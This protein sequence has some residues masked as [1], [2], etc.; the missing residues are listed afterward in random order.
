[1]KWQPRIRFKNRR[2]V[3]DAGILIL[4]M[5]VAIIAIIAATLAWSDILEVSYVKLMTELPKFSYDSQM[6][7]E[8]GNQNF[9][10][11][12]ILRNV[13]LVILV[14]VLFFA[15]MSFVFEH[16]NLIPP[17]TGYQI[18]SKSMI[19]IFFFFFFPPLWDLISTAVE[20]TSLW[21]LNP[22]D[23]TQPAKNVEFLL[24]KLGLID[25]PKF[26]LDA[27]VAGISDPFTSLKNMFLS[28]FLSIFKAVAFLIFM[29]M[30]FLFGTIRVVLTSIICVAI[31]VILMLSLIPFFKRV[32][33]RFIDA[34][35]GLIITPIFSSLVIV[36]GVA[37]LK[38]L[39]SSSPDPMVEW[40][41]AL[42]VM[43][44]ATF[45]PAMIVPMLNSVIGSVSSV[46]GRSV[47][48][49][50]QLTS[51]AGMGLGRTITDFSLLRGGIDQ[52]MSGIT[53]PLGLV[54]LAFSG[55][56]IPTIV[57]NGVSNIA[58]QGQIMQGRQGSLKMKEIIHGRQMF[59]EYNLEDNKSKKTGLDDS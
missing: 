48:T 44:L 49:G 50:M 30:A 4:G 28:I 33:N 39:E 8:S 2:G 25:S 9:E 18:L 53:E 27:I 47:S 56:P 37:H 1:M 12:Q 31:P 19:Y 5:I 29:F 13:A 20:Q 58:P 16:I 45:M 23:P 22:S 40:F 14:L 36:A 32:T 34:L 51:I 7:H 41:S 59:P 3:L 6:G 42:A 54:K 38:T 10:I 17:D 57:T 35:L 26:T 46:I 52:K 11:Y 55:S 43:A 24:S 15:G 21:I